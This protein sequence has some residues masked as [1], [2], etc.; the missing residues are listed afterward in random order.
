MKNHKNIYV[1]QPSL[2]DLKE[3]IPYLEEIW[4]SKRLTNNSQFHQ[5]LEKEMAEFLGV[6]HVALFANGTLALLTALQVLRITGEVITTP[7]SFVATANSLVWN[8]L[9]PVFVDVDSVYGNLDPEKIEEAIT[10]QTTAILPVHVYGNP[11]EVER[12][13]EIADVYGLK[14][15]YDA[16]HAF[17]NNFGDTSLLNFGDLAT[18]SFHA[19]KSYTTMEGGAIVCHDEKTKERIDYLKNF[20]FAGETKVMAPGINSKMNEMQAAL[21]LLQL[22]HHQANIRKRAETANQYKKEL[23]NVPGISVLPEYPGLTNYNYNYFPIFV[24][25]KEYGKSRDEL[26]FYLKEN[27][28]YGRR[29]F[30]PLI[31]DF[32]S[33]RGLESAKE[34]NLPNA[35]KIADKVICLPIYPGLEDK[36]VQ[37][38]LNLIKL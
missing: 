14:V 13:Q 31:S 24:D 18:L 8:N 27:G 16:A 28:I 15:I 9:K 19:T 32:P 22:K 35:K 5:Q 20:G 30:Y 4:K 12:I 33:Y 6:K 29:Y 17:G 1:T 34:E 2:P 23:Q 25:K 11:C 26:Y 36:D 37:K 10:P 3:F 21:G 7:Y 38:V